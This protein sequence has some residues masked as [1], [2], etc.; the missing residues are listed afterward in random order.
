M[1]S[2]FN[3]VLP[4]PIQNYDRIMNKS[5]AWNNFDYYVYFQLADAVNADGATV[6][7]VEKQINTLRN[8]AIA[9]SDGVPAVI[10][11]QCLTDIHLHSNFMLDVDGNG[12]I[13]YVRIFML[14]AIFIIFIACINFMNLA[15]ALSGTRGKGSGFAQDYR[16]PALAAGRAIYRRIHAALLSFADSGPGFSIYG[17]ALF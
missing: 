1:I 3:L 8:K 9:G 16:R 7:A 2:T 15:T 4:L 10:S 17:A 14:V 11:A 12:N 13:E 6:K 5:E